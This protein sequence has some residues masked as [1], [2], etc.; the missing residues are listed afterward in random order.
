MTNLNQ[1]VQNSNEMIFP[2]VRDL[3]A[4][5]LV[6]EPEEITQDTSFDDDDLDIMNTPHHQRI[7]MQVQ[8]KFP[9]LQLE[10]EMLRDC[11]TVAELVSVIEEEKEFADM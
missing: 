9:D 3:I 10:M 1:Q 4:E 2:V 5:T 8:K 6:Y 7:L 11:V